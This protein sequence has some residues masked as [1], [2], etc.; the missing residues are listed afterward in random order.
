MIELAMGLV[1][2]E[3]KKRNNRLERTPGC[4]PWEAAERDIG[5]VYKKQFGFGSLKS[6]GKAGS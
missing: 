3:G 4:S 5:T 2:S 1:V 6:M